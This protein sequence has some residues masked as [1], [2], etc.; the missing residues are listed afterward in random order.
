VAPTPG[1]A[2]HLISEPTADDL[3]RIRQ[4]LRTIGG[5]NVSW[6]AQSEL[7]VWTIEQRARLDLRMSERI[8]A[9]SWALVAVTVAL[10]ICTAALIWATLAA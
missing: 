7:E 2:P 10:V 1:P 8:T 6:G 4:V 9:A 3:A 5:P